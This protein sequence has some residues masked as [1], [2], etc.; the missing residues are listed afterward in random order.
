MLRDSMIQGNWKDDRPPVVPAGFLVE[1]NKRAAEL[2]D[3]YPEPKE[4]FC[5]LADEGNA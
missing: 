1:L 3:K 5:Q 4:A 2:I